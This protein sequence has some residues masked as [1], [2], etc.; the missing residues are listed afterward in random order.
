M[1]KLT[2]AE[3]GMLLELISNEHECISE[4]IGRGE[5]DEQ[6]A[7]D[8]NKTLAELATIQEKLT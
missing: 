5:L 3:K 2:E 6:G 4:M 1:T 8:G 7:K